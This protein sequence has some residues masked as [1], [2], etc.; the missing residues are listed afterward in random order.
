[1]TS[2]QTLSETDRRL[3]AAWAATCAE[4]VLPLFAS[5]SD[6]GRI[7]EAVA[8]A[9]AFG[10][11]ESTAGAEIARRMVAVS[12]AGS[13]TTPAGAAAARSAAQAA[14][15]A[16]MGAH[17]LGAAAYALKAVSLAHPGR[18]EAVADELRWQLDQLS[19]EARRALRLL[20]AVG[21]GSN[22]PLGQGLLSKGFLG[23]VVRRL[24]AAVVG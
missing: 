11:G 6:D 7:A 5:E 13:A 9:H 1:M 17:A 24:Q 22:G 15:V 14:A 2:P 10:A 3:L 20:P 21:S 12:A 19:P 18:P 16:H 4:R 8:R 23:E